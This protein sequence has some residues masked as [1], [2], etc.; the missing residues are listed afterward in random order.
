MET[1]LLDNGWLQ[2][3]DLP[4]W[5][6]HTITL[7]GAIVNGRPRVV[8]LHID[9][10]DSA[11]EPGITANRLRTVPLTD[12]ARVAIRLTRMADESDASDAMAAAA[13]R[14]AP[15]HDKRAATTVEQVAE[16]WLLARRMG[17]PPR[18]EVVDRLGITERTA[19][20][21]I[22]RARDAGLLPTDPKDT[23]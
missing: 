23:R 19:D 6:S 4:G 5:D 3:T 15:R 10:A 22:K 18:A 17:H 2:V 14:R 21:Y 11:T 13:V 9:L 7:R 1:H 12:L 8:A 20:R 16:I